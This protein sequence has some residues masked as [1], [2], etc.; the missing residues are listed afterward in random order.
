VAI[1]ITWSPPIT[2]A[3]IFVGTSALLGW[4]NNPWVW[5]QI[6]VEDQIGNLPF[7]S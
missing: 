2:A 7:A 1:Q 3:P 6:A 5:R 4:S